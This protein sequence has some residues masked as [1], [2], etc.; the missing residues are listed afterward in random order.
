MSNNAL[1]KQAKECIS[2]DDMYDECDKCGRPTLLHKEEECTRTV[3]EGLEV[4]AKN[5][6][7][8]RRRLKPILKEIQEERKK[9]AEQTVYLDGIEQIINQMTLS[10]K[11][12]LLKTGDGD[13]YS[14]A[15]DAILL[16]V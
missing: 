8:L 7:D 5:W 14:T 1:K 10:L 3:E 9:E 6:R 16:V 13:G 11:G 15:L 4:V 2:L 12:F